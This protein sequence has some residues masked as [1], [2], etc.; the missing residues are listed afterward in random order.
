MKVQQEAYK[1]LE[2]ARACQI[3]VNQDCLMP[4]PPLVPEQD[5]V[6]VHSAPYLKALGKKAN[7]SL[8]WIGAFPVLE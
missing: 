8:P 4:A 7:I 6:L 1:A 2:L 3:R 5:T